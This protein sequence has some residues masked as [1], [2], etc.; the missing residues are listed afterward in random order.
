MPAGGEVGTV[1]LLAVGETERHE[2][3]VVDRGEFGLLARLGRVGLALSYEVGH[4]LRRSDQTRPRFRRTEPQVVAVL[5]IALA[6]GDQISGTAV[7]L[8]FGSVVARSV[9]NFLARIGVLAVVAHEERF[10]V[11]GQLIGGDHLLGGIHGLGIDGVVLLAQISLVVQAQTGQQ[12]VGGTLV[13]ARIDLRMRS[14][15]VGILPGQLLQLGLEPTEKR[16]GIGL[17]GLG[18]THGLGFEDERRVTEAIEQHPVSVST[19][20]ADLG[21]LGRHLGVAVVGVAQKLVGIRNHHHATRVSRIDG[22]VLGR[23]P[24]VVANLLDPSVAPDAVGLVGR[25]RLDGP[26][27]TQELR[28]SGVADL[29]VGIACAGLSDEGETAVDLGQLALAQNGIGVDFA[30][31]NGRIRKRVLFEVAQTRGERQSRAKCE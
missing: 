23:G 1:H 9:D 13:D 22:V 5:E 29:D 16:H 3:A 14:L 11:V 10:V 20:E 21:T 15:E 28:S 18:G 6:G 24:G 2:R 4:E 25:E 19:Q 26:P 31:G 12:T 30:V 17:L 27:C 8:G 7:G